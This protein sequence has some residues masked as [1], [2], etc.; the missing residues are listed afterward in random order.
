M[1]SKRR[2]ITSLGTVCF[3]IYE[4]ISRYC[5]ASQSL[6]YRGTVDTQLIRDKSPSPRQLPV[7]TD[8]RMGK[9][10]SNII[11]FF[12]IYLYIYMKA[13]NRENRSF[14]HN[15]TESL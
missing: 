4:R 1:G 12:N 8:E 2:V 7:K 11:L 10:K 9:K 14:V 15:W 6:V 3:Q 5:L 13:K